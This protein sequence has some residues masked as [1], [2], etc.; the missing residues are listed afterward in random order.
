MKKISAICLFGG[1]LIS[2][3]YAYLTVRFLSEQNALN[4][5]LENVEKFALYYF[6]I[7]YCTAPLFVYFS[8]EKAFDVIRKYNKE[9]A[10]SYFVHIAS[11][12]T[13]LG[14][15][16]VKHP[17]SAYFFA[18]VPLLYLIPYF[19]VML[20]NYFLDPLFLLFSCIWTETR[21][22]VSDKWDDFRWKFFRR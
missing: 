1:L 15:F 16:L 21:I 13:K 5:K 14:Y 7:F 3:L 22:W 17:A 8:L 9:E 2:A 4:P 18:L 12:T 20:F 19:I 11:R 10:D 6:F